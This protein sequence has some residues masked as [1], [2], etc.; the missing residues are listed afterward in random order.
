MDLA[1][2][3]RKVFWSKVT[4]NDFRILLHGVKQFNLHPERG[5]KYLEE[6]GFVEPTPQSL[7]KLPAPANTTLVVPK[8]AQHPRVAGLP[9]TQPQ[10]TPATR[11]MPK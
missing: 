8:P 7:A 2:I 5:L 4:F 6:N 10:H 1:G 11:T 3:L 9:N